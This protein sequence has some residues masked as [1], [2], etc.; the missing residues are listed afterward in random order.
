MLDMKK[1]NKKNSVYTWVAIAALIFSSFLVA[2]RLI[3][4][5]SL[6]GTFVSQ[7][8]VNLFCENDTHFA[9]P[10][11]TTTF[12]IV[13]KNNGTTPDTIKLTANC[14]ENRAVYDPY[15]DKD[16]VHLLP[17]ESEKVSLTLSVYKDHFVG[18]SGGVIVTGVSLNNPGVD[19]QISL[20]VFIVD[21]DIS[22]GSD[23]YFISPGESANIKIEVANKGSLNDTVFLEVNYSKNGVIKSVRLE[24][25][26]VPDL[27][28]GYTGVN[29]EIIFRTVNL[30]VELFEKPSENEG[31]IEIQGV[32]QRDNNMTDSIRIT[33]RVK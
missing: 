33:I 17:G 26:I 3:E 8:D 10:G 1:I 9:L 31:F 2:E 15:F 30:T 13:V 19:C 23:E 12:E 7:Y 28:S 11:N 5:A 6:K 29:N 32:S 27:G 18:V 14:T 24:T 25:S 16:T 4:N 21:I 20:T 22:C